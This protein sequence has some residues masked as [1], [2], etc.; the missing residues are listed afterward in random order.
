MPHWRKATWAL[1]I[2]NV[3][4]A[5]WVIGGIS[6]TS[7][8]CN[9]MTGDALSTCQAGTAIGAGIGITILLILWFVLF[10]V[11]G[12]IWIMSR[13]RLRQCPRCGTD[14]KKGL[15]ACKTCGYD[16]AAPP[17]PVASA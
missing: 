10:V 13:P 4:M 12:L 8:N 14:V 5:V 16:F 9:G 2:V 6:S 7:H 17:A 1:I 3:L 11:F 15:T